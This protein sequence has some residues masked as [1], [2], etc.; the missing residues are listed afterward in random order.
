MEHQRRANGKP[1]PEEVLKAHKQQHRMHVIFAVLVVATALAA[2]SVVAAAVSRFHWKLDLTEGQIFRLTDTTKEVL[3]ELDQDVVITYCNSQAAADSNIEEVLNRYESGSDHIRVEYVDLNVNP[4][5]AQTYADRNLTLSEDGVLVESG[6]NTHFI[7]WNELYEISTYADADGNSQYT[8]TGLRAET[9][10][11]SALVKVTREDTTKVVF[12]NGHSEDVPDTL[13]ELITASN[14]DVEQ[15]VLG[16]QELP[17]Q[18]DTVIISGAKK[19]FSESEIALLDDYMDKGGNLI[20]FRDP[21]VETLGNLDAYLSE[22]GL[23]VGSE[24]V[25]EP[26]QQMDSPMNIIPN[27]GLSMINVHFSEQSTYLVLPEVRSLTI[28]STNNC[29]VNEVLKSTSSSYGKPYGSMGSTK[30]EENDAAGPFT[31]AAT[32]ERTYSGEEEERT[33]YVFLTACTNFYQRSYL[34]T[35]SLGNSD[36]VLEV[37]SF[38]ND[39]S[40]SLNIPT[41]NIAAGSISISWASTVVFAAVFVVLIPA[42]LLIS[43]IVIYFRRRHS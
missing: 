38:M 11:T 43:G 39:T 28:A 40:V 22:W 6:M 33:Q 19:D 7:A 16:V 5:F 42:V 36:F 27:F 13:T 1:I 24:I 25:M 29:I 9:Q 8:L 41:K 21:E 35:E 34:E 4:A 32:S 20:V 17:A 12:T 23:T 14:Y 18:T 2:Y 3:S 10:L 15:V 31:V 26:S 37:L 30:K